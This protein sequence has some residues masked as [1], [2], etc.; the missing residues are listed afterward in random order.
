[1]ENSRVKQESIE[2]YLKALIE[3]R[4]VL[5]YTNRIS[6]DEFSVKNNLS[7]NLSK[8]LQKGGIIKCLKRG[9]FSEW[10][11]TTIEPTNHMAVKTIQLLGIENPP[12]KPQIIKKEVKVNTRGG[13]R[14]NSGRKTKEQEVK[15][16]ITDKKIKVVLFWGLFTFYFN[17]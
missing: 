12:R 6:L 16:L 2:K 8:V 9:R 17:V 13:A 11:W 4:N 14:A 7:K 10:E 3:L 1:M 5:K 15:E